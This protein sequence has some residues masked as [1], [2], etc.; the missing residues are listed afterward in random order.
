MTMDVNSR[1]LLNRH[2]IL[3]L[4]ISLFAI[5]GSVIVDSF[6]SIPSCKLCKIQR[7]GFLIL[8]IPAFLGI[9]LESKRIALWVASIVSAT[10]SAVALYHLSIQL[11]LV[12]D[13]CAVIIP[14]DIAG[15]KMLLF[16][17][18]TSCSKMP[19][20]LGLPVSVWSLFFS[21]FCFTLTARL[22]INHPHNQENVQ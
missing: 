15:L 20:I 22:L 5:A 17:N 6:L 7:G 12:A 14:K 19:L 9:F 4:A 10:I 3:V 16:S 18:A 21:L 8:T 11:G 1:I 2:L 13:P